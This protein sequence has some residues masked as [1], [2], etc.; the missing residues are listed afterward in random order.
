LGVVLAEASDFG[1]RRIGE[2][3]PPEAKPVL[4]ALGVWGEP[5]D[6]CSK[7]SLGIDSRWASEAVQRYDYFFNLNGAGRMLDRAAFDRML[8][9][10]ARDSG[11]RLL[12]RTRVGQVQRADDGEWTVALR[13]GEDHAAIRCRFVVDATGRSSRI[14]RTLVPRR[15]RLDR[16]IG[17]AVWSSPSSRRPV[18]SSADGFL[19]IEAVEDGWWYFGTLPGDEAV[20]VLM[21]DA[22]LVQTARQAR[23]AWSSWWVTQANQVPRL[24]SLLASASG[25]VDYAA[26]SAAS[27]CLA[28]SSGDGWIAVGDASM[29]F[30]PLSSH[31]IVAAL[32]SGVSAAQAIVATLSGD[33]GLLESYACNARFTF[34]DYVR[35]RIQVYAD[36]EYWKERPFWSRRRQAP[37]SVGEG[38]AALRSRV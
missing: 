15:Q 32:Q 7:P 21:T 23:P 4:E 14:A 11:A 36:V 35:R 17:L 37:T 16:E 2:H 27:S 28:Q 31:G 12:E 22:D 25:P 3:L 26:C 24:R 1:G 30:D 13:R 20:A 8:A 33:S 5:T 6:R 29:A 9:F 10:A 34:A 38:D 18:E 19:Q